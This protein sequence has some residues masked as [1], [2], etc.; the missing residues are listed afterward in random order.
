MRDREFLTEVAGALYELNMFHVKR[1]E[2]EIELRA[3]GLPTEEEEKF[4]TAALAYRTALEAWLAQ[5]K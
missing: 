4:L 2:Q 5:G 1:V 3:P